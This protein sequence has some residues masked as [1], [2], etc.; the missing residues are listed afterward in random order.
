MGTRHLVSFEDVPQLSL[1][2]P[3]FAQLEDPL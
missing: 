2:W 1:A 3:R